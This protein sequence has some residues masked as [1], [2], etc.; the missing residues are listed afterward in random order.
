[1]VPVGVPASEMTVTLSATVWPKFDGFGVELKVV[2]VAAL[3]TT[4]VTTAEVEAAKS[5]EPR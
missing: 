5:I 1:M 4:W 2:A 3:L